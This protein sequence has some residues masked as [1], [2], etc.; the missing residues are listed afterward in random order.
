MMLAGR[1]FRGGMRAFSTTSPAFKVFYTKTHEWV[2]ITD[3]TAKIGI[4]DFAQNELG[5][6]VYVDLPEAGDS[7]TA[8]EEYGTIESVKATS[9]LISPVGGTVTTINDAVVDDNALVNDDPESNGWL[10]TCDVTEVPE[11]LMSA[12]EYAAYKAQSESE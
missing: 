2:D 12:E 1:A 10:I 9:S 11:D 4:T 3:K 5:E 6:V 8:G 7:L